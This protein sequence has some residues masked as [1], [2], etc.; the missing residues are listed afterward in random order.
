MSLPPWL[1]PLTAA[2]AGQRQWRVLDVSGQ[3]HH[4]LALYAAVQNT[5]S[6]SSLNIPQRL[7][8]VLWLADAQALQQQAPAAWQGQLKGLLPGVHRISLDSGE[9]ASTSTFQLTLWLGDC[10]RLLRQEQMLADSLLLGA[11]LRPWLAPHALKPLLR[12]VQRGSQLLAAADADA[13]ALAQV[14][15]AS[16]WQLQPS[17][18]N[19]GL[20]AGLC[21]RFDPPWQ[22]RHTPPVA[23]TSGHALV[24]GAGL[25][26][27]AVAYSLAQRGW[28]VTV[29]G[30]GAAPADGAS[31]LPAGLF[32]PHV[33]PDDCSLSR[34]SRAGLRALLPRL[35]AL[36][37][38][39]QD[40]M[41]TGVLER[42]PASQIPPAISPDW[43]GPAS[44]EQRQAAGL[45]AQDAAL[46]HAWAGW[47][48]PRRLVAAQLGQA[49][50]DFCG[51]QQ[52]QQLQ[53]SAQG[54]WRALDAQGAE[55]A[56]GDIAIIAAGA[57]SGTWLPAHWRLQALRGQVSLG[58]HT[59]ETRQ[60][61]PPFAV[62]GAGNFVPHIPC[63]AQGQEPL[64]WVMGSTFE[65]DMAELPISPEAQASAHAHNL[66]KLQS[67]LPHTAAALA[68]CFTSGKPQCQA[69]WGQVRL[70]SH[71]RLPIVGPVPAPAPGLWALTALG[72]RG[73]SLAVL[74]AE[75]LAARLHAEPLLLEAALARQVDSG[76][77]G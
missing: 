22:L 67:L 61:M 74:C 35:Q 8:Y 6:A 3:P 62:N 55:L 65:R 18:P 13:L 46:W 58:L 50:I 15:A 68:P 27:S 47:L 57:A 24:L 29:L 71:D 7:H 10:P 31:G 64:Q 48:I 1:L 33:S 77:M 16:G 34:L 26:G 37:V 4:L 54:G 53:P 69:T 52:V 20:C 23:A 66:A 2:W 45:T 70:A 72:A 56:Q 63:P 38:A 21:V 60:A 19:A 42:S 59:P 5:S 75:L 14:L 51:Q 44:P 39:G 40:W 41:Q 9:S 30:A 32:C 28:R 43:S 17:Q 49:G 76:R 25:A 73:I 11:G 12:H 36:C